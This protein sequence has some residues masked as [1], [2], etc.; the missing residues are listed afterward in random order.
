MG[1]FRINYNK[2]GPGVP[3]D[4]PRKKGAARFFEV[5]MRDFWD[6][7]KLNMLFCLFVLPT[8]AAFFLGLLGFMPGIMFIVALFAAF[9]V[10]GAV[11]AL[12]FNIT[13][14]LRDDPSYVWNDFWR[15]FKQNYR[16]ASAPGMLCTA[17]IYAQIL[18]WTSLVVSEEGAFAF[19]AVWFFVAILVL[20]LFWMITPYIFMHY[21]YIDLKTPQIIKNSVLMSFAYIPRSFMG[22]IQGGVMWIIFAL[23]FPISLAY[24]PVI[25]IF[26]I[27]VSFLLCLMWTWPPF[28][29]YFGV[30]EALIK[31]SKSAAGEDDEEEEDSEEE[32]EFK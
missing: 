14:F 5:L 4:L 13:I 23:Y 29:K 30:E 32:S 21:A 15:K 1:L 20:V 12:M 3:K 26:G 27:S 17:F 6:L 24:A 8:V 22:A 19:D 31:R 25:M 11:V 28:E 9:P 16:S 18:M 10:G 2:P 7:I